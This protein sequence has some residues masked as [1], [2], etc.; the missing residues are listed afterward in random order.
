MICYRD[1]T[2]CD[3]NE[4]KKFS[5]CDRALT[6]GVLDKAKSINLPVCKFIDKPKCFKKK[7]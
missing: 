1:R 5:K 3:Y 2:Y 6:V 4:C 7:R